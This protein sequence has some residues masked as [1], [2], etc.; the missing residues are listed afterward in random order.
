M[1]NKFIVVQTVLGGLLGYLLGDW[2]I[3]IKTLVMFMTLDYITGLMVG[4]SNHNLS[5]KVGYKGLLKKMLILFIVAMATRL[6]SV[7]NSGTTIRTAVIFYYM[8]NEGISILENANKL[9]I[10][11]P[12]KLLKTLEQFN[13][14]DNNIEK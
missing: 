4:A 10:K 12:K 2:D 9:G 11:I 1:E 6:D 5:S 14:E 8:S 13:E 7:M 3:F